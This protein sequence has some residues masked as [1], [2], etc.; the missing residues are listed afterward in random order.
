MTQIIK[1]L[2]IL[3]KTGFPRILGPT[4]PCPNAVGM[5][6]FSSFGLQA[7]SLEYLLLPP[8]SALKEV[9]I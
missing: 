4:D 2:T 9:S 5:E 8:R 3:A 6:P 7:V 1:S